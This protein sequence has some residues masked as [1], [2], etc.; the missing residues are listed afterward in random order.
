MFSYEQALFTKRDLD[1]HIARGTP[2]LGLPAHPRCPFCSGMAPFYTNDELLKHKHDKHLPCSLCVADGTVDAF[3][4]N[5]DAYKAH[6]IK[7]HHPCLQ[8]GC[9]GVIVFRS[10]IE[11]HVSGQ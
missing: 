8:P 5:H 10:P 1:S 3:F 7:A 2:E 6:A 11:L 9:D 4:R